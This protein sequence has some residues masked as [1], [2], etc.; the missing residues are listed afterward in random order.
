M[1][2]AEA[3][4][5]QGGAQLRGYSYVKLN[6]QDHLMRI[7]DDFRQAILTY[8]ADPNRAAVVIGLWYYE[9][10]Y[11]RSRHPSWQAKWDELHNTEGD[12]AA[13]YSLDFRLQEAGLLS[14]LGKME[15]MTWAP[16][17]EV[18]RKA[19]AFLIA[20]LRRR[21]MDGGNGATT[22]GDEPQP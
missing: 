16:Q 10:G 15:S 13:G 20:R 21:P 17:D 12:P 5:E 9:L 18:D 6:D 8:E 19:E 3:G 4:Q 7:K 2:E 22:A 11:H 14:E 1:A